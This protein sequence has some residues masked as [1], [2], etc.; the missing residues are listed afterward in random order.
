MDMI[1]HDMVQ[2][3]NEALNDNLDVSFDFEST[4]LSSYCCKTM[5]INKIKIKS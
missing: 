3:V 1:R 2:A 5:K 4:S